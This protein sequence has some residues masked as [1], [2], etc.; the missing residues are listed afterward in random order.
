MHDKLGYMNIV[1]ISDSVGDLTDIHYYCSDFC[2]KSDPAYDGWYGCVEAEFSTVC[3][4][5][6]NPIKGNE[7]S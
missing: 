4:G 6:G 7:N 1:L 2:A 5:C 3:Q